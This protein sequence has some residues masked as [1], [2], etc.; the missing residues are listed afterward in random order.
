MM[1]NKD[2][3][4]KS[5][6]VRALLTLSAAGLLVFAARHQAWMGLVADWK[7]GDMKR[8]EVLVQGSWWWGAVLFAGILGSLALTAPWWRGPWRLAEPGPE[9]PVSRWFLV[10]LVVVMAG[11]A[12]LRVPR[13]GLSFYN[14]ESY[15]FRRHIA[16]AQTPAT[17]TKP[18][19]FRTVT[20]KET[21][22]QNLTGNNSMV[23]SVLARSSYEGW[24][25][26]SGQPAGT[27]CE[28]AVR[29]PVF[30]CGVLAIGA[31]GWLGMRLGGPRLGV[32]VAVL[33][34]LHPWQVRYSTEARCYGI[35]L[36]LLPL[37]FLALRA[38]LRT[39]RWRAWLLFGAMEYLTTACFF[40]AAHLLI[41]LNLLVA[42]G[43][44]VMAGRP[45]PRR[46]PDAL[47]CLVPLVVSGLLASG[48]YLALNLPLF[49]QT[50]RLVADQT[51]LHDHF[52]PDWF[53][54]VGS[55]LA[56]GIPGPARVA[57]GG[58]P[59]SFARTAGSAPW[60][61]FSM[62]GVFLICLGWGGARLGR[63]GAT[64]R[65]VPLASLLGAALTLAYC[66]YQGLVLLPWYSIFLLP[67]VLLAVAAGLEGLWEYSLPLTGPMP[68]ALAA[69]LLLSGWVTVLPFYWNSSREN[70]RGVVQTV[71]PGDALLGVFW[72]EAPVYDHSA[73][74]LH[75]KQDLES[76]MA[77][78][79]REHRECYVDAMWRVFV[80]KAPADQIRVVEDP[81][82]FERI[83]VFPGLDEPGNTH[84]LWRMRTAPIPANANSATAQHP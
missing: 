11:G 70:L 35:L 75:T 17:G 9:R 52:T 31:M 2:N 44:V 71:R 21:C 83:A 36:L 33:T 4:T 74:V 26:A 59:V 48:L 42:G 27:V 7:A 23:F 78:A 1:W 10:A 25:K 46:W 12:A 38:A 29:L 58:L 66:L 63:M 82:Q 54:D 6:L 73:V 39:G 49:L 32:L 69:A 47:P 81:G 60:L 64:A 34:A 80:M 68:G 53:Q 5:C 43:A 30:I 14:D 13:L 40:G 84:V 20:W 65:L 8:L 61:A 18:P 67:A 3:L 28:W 15:S 22:Y 55:F 72:S 51:Y 45:A 50:V 16:G 41:G 79:Q 77:R 57:E 56:F 37:L 62:L 24:K 19:H 76:L